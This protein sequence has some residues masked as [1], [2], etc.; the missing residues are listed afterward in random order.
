MIN[1]DYGKSKYYTLFDTYEESNK[2]KGNSY[3]SNY[4]LWRNDISNENTKQ[5]FIGEFPKEE[6]KNYL[7]NKIT[8]NKFQIR[9]EIATYVDETI[10]PGDKILATFIA[11]IMEHLKGVN[12]G[13]LFDE[14]MTDEWIV[15]DVIDSYRNGKALRKMVIVKD[16]F[17]N[18]YDQSAG[19]DSQKQVIPK[20]KITD[21][22]TAI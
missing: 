7:N 12:Q 6:A 10:Q 16:S 8:K 2:K 4:A 13:H 21:R 11:G 9:C 19:I 15:E 1:L 14:H 17:F 22:D 5:F 20:V 18:L 3:F